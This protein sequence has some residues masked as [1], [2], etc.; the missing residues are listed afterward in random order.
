MLILVVT[1][2]DIETSKSV[3]TAGLQATR[4]LLRCVGEPA[5]D[6]DVILVRS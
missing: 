4:A 1:R 2:Y 3:A 6:V 5:A